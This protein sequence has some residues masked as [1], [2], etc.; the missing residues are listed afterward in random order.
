M[1]CDPLARTYRWLEYLRFGKTLE[2]CRCSMLPFLT[3]SRKAL[4]LGDGDGRF[5]EA[6]ARS[7]EAVAIDVLEKSLEM[8]QV[9]N[10][11]VK[12]SGVQDRVRFTAGDIITTLPPDK[13]YDLIASHFFFD[14]F[15]N[16]QVNGII[17]QIGA[18]A[19][20][21]VVWLVSEFD[22]P[23]QGW[24]RVHAKLWLKIMYI[25][26]GLTTG[27]ENQ[28]LPDWRTSLKNAG[29]GLHKRMALRGGFIV[30]ELWNRTR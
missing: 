4:L 28:S 10:K 11:R 6:F 27:L 3:T 24:R 29:F 12:R 25:F 21:S 16:A 17:Q 19:N 7:N 2:Y 5:L 14:V 15:T 30:S 13:D 1:N 26:F 9:A 22:L 23:A 18:L 8:I 20:P